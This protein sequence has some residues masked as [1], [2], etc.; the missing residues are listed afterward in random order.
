MTMKREEVEHN[1]INTEPFPLEPRYPCG[2]KLEQYSVGKKYGKKVDR[3]P[4]VVGEIVAR[5]L[6]IPSDN[7]DRP[8]FAPEE[9]TWIY[10]VTYRPVGPD[11]VAVQANAEDLQEDI[12]KNILKRMQDRRQEAYAVGTQVKKLR[13]KKLYGIGDYNCWCPAKIISNNNASTY[14]YTIQYEDGDHDELEHNEINTEPFPLE[15]RYPCGLK[16]EQYMAWETVGTKKE[17]VFACLVGDIIARFLYIPMSRFDFVAE[18]TWMYS[19]KYR[20][21]MANADNLFEIKITNILE[22]MQQRKQE[23]EAKSQAWKSITDSTEGTNKDQDVCLREYFAQHQISPE[24]I[25]TS[26]HVLQ[27]VAKL[28]LKSS[29]A[30]ASSSN[31]GTEKSKKRN[32]QQNNNS[33]SNSNDADVAGLE[34]ENNSN[35]DSALSEVLDLLD[36][37]N[38]NVRGQPAGLNG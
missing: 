12:I 4:Y 10:S 29:S 24:D 22:R 23:E 34:N 38:R 9:P 13:R 26:I 21:N 14:P 37:C 16:L 19:L 28:A 18:P 33:D 5:F 11:V 31:N 27:V 1:E 3:F 35:T 20:E 15:P 36:N 32:R 17:K 6:Y 30:S 2:M 25:A 8:R 7:S